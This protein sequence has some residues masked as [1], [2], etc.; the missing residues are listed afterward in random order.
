[1]NTHPDGGRP[2]RPRTASTPATRSTQS[3]VIRRGS[4]AK[5]ACPPHSLRP[6]HQPVTGEL[7]QHRPRSLKRLGA[8]TAPLHSDLGQ[9]HL[10]TISAQATRPLYLPANGRLSVTFNLP[11]RR[12]D[13]YKIFHNIAPPLDIGPKLAPKC[14]TVIVAPAA[15][16]GRGHPVS[17][18][19]TTGRS[20]KSEK[21]IGVRYTSPK[22]RHYER[23]GYPVTIF[24][25]SRQHIFSA[26]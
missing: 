7:Q 26:A 10:D 15:P 17:V 1:M 24:F 22:Y 18:R 16:R 6:M 21:M 8:S 5:S 14:A 25:A 11:H 3:I 20:S 13:F 12:A 4:A 19:S 23:P 2:G 9:S